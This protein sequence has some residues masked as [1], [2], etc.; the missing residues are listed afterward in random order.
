MKSFWWFDT[1]FLSIRHVRNTLEIPSV[2]RS[3]IFYLANDGNWLW[4]NL[5][6]RCPDWLQAAYSAMQPLD[7]YIYIYISLAEYMNVCLSFSFWGILHMSK[8]HFGV[9]LWVVH[10]H[11]RLV[12]HSPWYPSRRP[13]RHCPA[14]RDRSERNPPSRTWGQKVAGC[15]NT[16]QCLD[17]NPVFFVGKH[18]DHKIKHKHE[19]NPRKKHIYRSIYA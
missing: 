3:F 12:T 5:Y 8:F 18:Q 7:V 13:S 17:K 11:R 4:C 2:M 15:W 1:T 19:V 14:R 16:L 9:S 10:H 6:H